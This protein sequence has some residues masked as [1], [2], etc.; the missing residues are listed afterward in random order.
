MIRP[1]DYC[2]VSHRLVFSGQALHAQ[3]IVVG[4]GGIGETAMGVKC[5][6]LLAFFLFCPEQHMIVAANPFLLV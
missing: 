6:L 2:C 4:I 5:P 1:I 3:P